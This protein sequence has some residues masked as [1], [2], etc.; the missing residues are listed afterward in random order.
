MEKNREEKTIR[1]LVIDDEPAVRE[2]FKGLLE[3]EGFEVVDAGDGQ[4]GIELFRQNPTDIVI[5]DIIMPK[6]NGFEVI[7]ELQSEYPNVKII[8]ISG[9][10]VT[11]SNL[12]QNGKELT[13]DAALRKPVELYDLLRVIN[14]LLEKYNGQ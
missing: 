5:T 1:I 13:V 4:A 2:V 8:V 11:D 3:G 9:S 10:H 7:N 12:I 6:K 14:R